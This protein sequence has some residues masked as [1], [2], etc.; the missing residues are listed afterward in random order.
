MAAVNSLDERF[1]DKDEKESYSNILSIPIE[2]RKIMLE[3]RNDK[4]VEK[5]EQEK[6]SQNSIIHGADEVGDNNDELK[7]N[8]AH[9]IKDI[10]TQ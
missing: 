1:E 9:Y 6:I 4:K 7:E 5:V 3:I 10:L 8:D 2:I